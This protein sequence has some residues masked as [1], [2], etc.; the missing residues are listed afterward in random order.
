M[1]LGRSQE[2][3]GSSLSNWVPSPQMEKSR[4]GWSRASDKWRS[5]TNSRIVNCV[6]MATSHVR[7]RGKK[8]TPPI[9]FVPTIITS[10]ILNMQ[11]LDLGSNKHKIS[12]EF[13]P[14]LPLQQN[15]DLKANN[16][17]NLN[18]IL[19]QAVTEYVCNNIWS[20]L[21]LYDKLF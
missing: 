13:L 9:W 8:S 6:E 2:L 5:S 3:S 18:H 1:G 21:L 10:K 17:L 15:S 11:L 7:I 14:K 20:V 4:L 19:N 12:Y 16:F